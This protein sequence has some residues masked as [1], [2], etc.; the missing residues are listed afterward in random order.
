MK[1]EKWTT[2]A[3][4]E[5]WDI[6]L[7]PPANMLLVNIPVNEYVSYQYTMNTISGAWSRWTGIPAKSW[8]YAEDN[9]WVGMNGVVGKAWDTQSDNGSPIVADILPAYQSF[10]TN[11]QLKRWTLGRFIFG[12]NADASYGLRLE[13]DFSIS[14]KPFPI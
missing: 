7:F 2:Y 11:S 12:A 13:T 5:G 4:N 3:N 10:G 14:D 8:Y 6:M 1:W 9:L